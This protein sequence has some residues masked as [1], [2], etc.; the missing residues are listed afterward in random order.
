MHRGENRAEEHARLQAE[1]RAMWPQPRNAKSYQKPRS[2]KGTET[3]SR[4]NL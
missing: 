3:K 4:L 2:W 1:S